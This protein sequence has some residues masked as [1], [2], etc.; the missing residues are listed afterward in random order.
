LLRGKKEG[1]ALQS[2]QY[3]IVIIGG[4][5]NG[6]VCAFYCARAGL[7]VLVLLRVHFLGGAAVS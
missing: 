7:K 6:L 5:H 3:D 1:P 4:G 2:D